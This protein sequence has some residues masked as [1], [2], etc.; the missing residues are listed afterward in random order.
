MPDQLQKL[1]R[2]DSDRATFV[3]RWD[4]M[5]DQSPAGDCMTADRSSSWQF[6]GIF[7]G[8]RRIN[9]LIKPRN[10]SRKAA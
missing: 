8:T 9:I 2:A 10:S 1:S 6:V 5:D 3:V 7:V 4:A